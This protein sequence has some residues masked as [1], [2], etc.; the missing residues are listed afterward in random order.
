MSQNSLDSELELRWRTWLDKGKRADRLADK[1][2]K[3]LF[4]V[5]GIVLLT[6]ILFYWFHTRTLPGSNHVQP[7]VAGHEP[8][9][10]MA[11]LRTRV[12]G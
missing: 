5:V 8:L 7:D 1:R 3:V 10:P 12:A 4:S 6:W 9:S 11:V 2:M